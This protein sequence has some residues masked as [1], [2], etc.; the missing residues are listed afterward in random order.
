MQYFADFPGE[1]RLPSPDNTRLMDLLSS[2]SFSY[3][4]NTNAGILII[5]HRYLLFTVELINGWT[6]VMSLVVVKCG[7]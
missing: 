1:S 5:V 3:N 2:S 4:I 7:T 6:N